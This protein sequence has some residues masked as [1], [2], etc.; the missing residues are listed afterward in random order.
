MV[1]QL[2]SSIR[3]PF[4]DEFGTFRKDLNTAAD[5]VMEEIGLAAREQQC[6]EANEAALERKDASSFRKFSIALLK[7]ES[8]RSNKWREEKMKARY[9]NALSTYNAET[10]FNQ[11]RKKGSST[12]ILHDDRYKQW[13]SSDVKLT[14]LC[15]G[16]VGAGKT[17]ACASVVEDLLLQRSP[18]SVTAY[19]FCRP[20]EVA[21]LKAR[22]ILGC[23]ARQLFEGSPGDMSGFWQK[24]KHLSMDQIVSDM[25]SRLPETCY[26]L[27]IDGLDECQHEEVDL[28]IEAIQSIGSLKHTF[29]LFLTG[30]SD[31]SSIMADRL[32]PEY[33]I[34]M[35][36]SLNGPEI[37]AY[38]ELTLEEALESGR[39]KLGDPTIILDIQAALETGAQGM[40]V[41]LSL[42]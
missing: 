6:Q 7:N 19:F 8:E 2:A 38:I 15:S 27:A 12:W 31:L 40:F 13:L 25:L 3:K 10:A 11:A 18:S 21:S 33:Y 34:S 1:R 29:K 20:D 37:S 28:L 16:I 32:D 9:L 39:L 35:T 36:S 30:R 23:L 42:I 17:I 14:L 26:I 22:E 4:D 24:E 41:M 5:N